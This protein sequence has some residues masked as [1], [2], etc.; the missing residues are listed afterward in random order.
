MFSALLEKPLA[1]GQE[2]QCDETNLSK[3]VHNISLD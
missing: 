2:K 3:N 1:D